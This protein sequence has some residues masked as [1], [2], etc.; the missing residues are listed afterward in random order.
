MNIPFEIEEY[1]Q[2]NGNVPFSNW[3]E[4]QKDKTIKRK[5]ASRIRR[6]SFGNFGD[7]RSIKGV[8]G[9]LEM[10]EHYGSGFRIFFSIIENK[11]ILLLIGSSK[12][13]QKQAIAKAQNYLL[14][15]KNRMKD[16]NKT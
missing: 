1:V 12:K 15:Y 6:A 9:L 13:D 4:K 14:D 2:E 11:V 7:Y 10:R 3:L 16:E 5:I 8:Q